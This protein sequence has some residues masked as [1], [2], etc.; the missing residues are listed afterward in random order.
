[1]EIWEKKPASFRI[2]MILS[3]IAMFCI[4]MFAMPLAE[5]EF[6]KALC[7]GGLLLGPVA[8]FGGILGY[9]KV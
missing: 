6:A 5:T 3:G 2:K 7:A 1:M 9:Q 8:V 4:G